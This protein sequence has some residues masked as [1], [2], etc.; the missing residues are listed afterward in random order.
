MLINWRAPQNL[1]ASTYHLLLGLWLLGEVG[2]LERGDRL[3][4]VRKEQA[5]A[6]VGGQ[7]A[8]LLLRF[9]SFQVVVGPVRVD[10]QF[11]INKISEYDTFSTFTIST[12]KY[13]FY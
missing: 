10:L 8:D 13:I 9:G 4:D 11:K 7:I 2:H 5:I 1:G 12:L 6:T 3:D